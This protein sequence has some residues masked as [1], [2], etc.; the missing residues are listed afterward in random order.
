[1]SDTSSN[2]KAA[3]PQ[4]AAQSVFSISRLLDAIGRH[5]AVLVVLGFILS[6]IVGTHVTKRI[7]E[8]SKQREAITRDRD[9]LRSAIDDLRASFELYAAGTKHVMM[10]LE[11][12]SAE[13][14]RQQALKDYSAAYSTW[15]Q[16]RVIDYTAIEQRFAGTDNG[17]TITSIGNL[18][19][20]GTEQL[21]NCIQRHLEAH[22]K[23]DPVVRGSL[24]CAAQFPVTEYKVDSRLLSL[25]LCM[26]VLALSI[27]PHPLSD[28]EPA[29]KRAI[30]TAK[31]L[32]Q[33]EGACSPAPL[34]GLNMPLKNA[35]TR[36]PSPGN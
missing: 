4:P 35:P 29:S 17:N 26:R 7:D 14:L 3:I 23:A 15:V 16:R 19:E 9:S 8:Y 12:N 24:I 27:R 13:D 1:M 2:Y 34:A 36:D 20:I 18:L 31:F 25:R 22:S 21:D 10:T 33:I 11:S 6:G 28:F 30:V 32:D 5:P